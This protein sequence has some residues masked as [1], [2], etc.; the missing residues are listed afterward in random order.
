MCRMFFAVG[1]CV[2]SLSVFAGRGPAGENI[3]RKA[4]T[5][6]PEAEKLLA[7]WKTE[8]K[9]CAKDLRSHLPIFRLLCIL[10]SA[11]TCF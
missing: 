4:W 3:Q 11:T 7:K 6:T 1:L 10:E 8:A 2:L 9:P 5:C